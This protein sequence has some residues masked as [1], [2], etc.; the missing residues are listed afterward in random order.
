MVQLLA[1]TSKPNI[2]N[3]ELMQLQG[4]TLTQTWREASDKDIEKFK[5]KVFSRKNFKMLA[6]KVLTKIE[7]EREEENSQRGES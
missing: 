5:L 7:E 1:L 4:P 6:Q 3:E 2:S